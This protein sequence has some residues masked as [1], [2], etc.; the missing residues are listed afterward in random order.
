MTKYRAFWSPPLI[1][2]FP[3]KNQFALSAR[4]QHFFPVSKFYPETCTRVVC[5]R[6]LPQTT[7]DALPSNA[8]E[9]Y[10]TGQSTVSIVTSMRSAA[11][12]LT[13]SVLPAVCTSSDP[14]TVETAA[15][16]LK[17]FWGE[18]RD[19]ASGQGLPSWQAVFIYI[20]H[21][22]AVPTSRRLRRA[23]GVRSSF[24]LVRRKGRL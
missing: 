5:G 4:L 22:A 16:E 2:G 10:G 6:G 24:C 17:K 19:A 18:L 23:Y 1:V 12:P 15:A 9:L 14:V 11:A 7:V 8:G 20:R 21:T 13:N 3:L